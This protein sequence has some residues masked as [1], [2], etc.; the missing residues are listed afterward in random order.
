MHSFHSYDSPIFFPALFSFSSSFLRNGVEGR[1]HKK[2]IVLK[3]PFSDWLGKPVNYRRQPGSKLVD[4]L[5]LS[6]GRGEQGTLKKTVQTYLVLE[7]GLIS[8]SYRCNETGV[9]MT[10]L[11]RKRPIVFPKMSPR[12]P[13]SYLASNQLPDG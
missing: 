13:A 10:F 9:K 11:F 5:W 8:T 7:N 12:T 2:E 4:F 1:E 3:V 6:C